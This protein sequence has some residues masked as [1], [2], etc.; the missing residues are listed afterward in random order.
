MGRGLIKIVAPIV[1]VI[2]ASVVFYWVASD[3]SLASGSPHLST[4]SFH[5]VNP[6][7]VENARW[8]INMIV[9]NSG[10][11]TGHVKTVYVNRQEVDV[12]GVI[13]GDKLSN[14]SF[15]ATSVPTD[16]LYVEPGSSESF[17][18]WIGAD[19][20]MS[21]IDVSLNDVNDLG[22]LRTVKLN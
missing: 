16:G 11:G 21:Q 3:T 14:S 9:S 10:T 8:Q 5:K 19:L 12:Y 15:V 1:L 6:I 2:S 7:S 18:I 20:R 17:I 13:H 22:T 4:A